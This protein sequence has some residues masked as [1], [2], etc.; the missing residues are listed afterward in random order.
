MWIILFALT[1]YVSVGSI[2]ASFALPFATWFTTGNWT[3][4][5]VTAGMGAL[6][7][8]KHKANIQRLLKG[9]ESRISF[10]RKPSTS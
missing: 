3:L 10:K 5:A 8:Y 6:A 7:I 1:R 9:T 4:T 2:A